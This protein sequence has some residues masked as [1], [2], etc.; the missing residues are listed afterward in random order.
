[1]TTR[2]TFDRSSVAS[3]SGAP[4]QKPERISAIVIR[5]LRLLP[6]DGRASSPP[7]RAR[8]RPSACS[9]ATSSADSSTNTKPPRK[10]ANPSAL[11]LGVVAVVEADADDLRRLGMIEPLLPESR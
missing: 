9:A 7:D 3:E 1:M 6:P 4:P 10:F 2:S 8:V 11:L 5:A